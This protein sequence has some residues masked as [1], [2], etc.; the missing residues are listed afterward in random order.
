MVGLRL[1]ECPESL[2][3]PQ[4]RLSGVRVDPNR[5]AKDYRPRTSALRPA[6]G[7]RKTLFHVAPS[8]SV[9]VPEP[10]ICASAGTVKPFLNN[11]GTTFGHPAENPRCFLCLWLQQLTNSNDPKSSWLE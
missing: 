2:A 3:D 6:Q 9:V 8:C 10:I 7:C 1:V 11:D 4:A 5:M